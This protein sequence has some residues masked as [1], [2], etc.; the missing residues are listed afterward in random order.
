MA[1]PASDSLAADSARSLALVEAVAHYAEPLDPDWSDTRRRVEWSDL[2]ADGR[3]DALVYLIGPAWCGSGGCTLLVME[4]VAPDDVDEL[5]AF[6]PAAEISLMHGP[7]AV[8]PTHSFGWA[9][10]IVED[11][12]GEWQKLSF[13]GE[14][15]PF[16]PADGQPIDAA[17]AATWFFADAQPD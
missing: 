7:V 10:L 2:N 12:D 14:T 11:H 9:D 13:D 4:A 1:R 6:R 3:A 17:D 16:S 15:Y 8:A 5:G